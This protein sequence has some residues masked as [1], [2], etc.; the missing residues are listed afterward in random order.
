MVETI[1]PGT[2]ITVRDEGLISAGNI[3]SGIIGVVGTAAKGEVNKVYILS[4]I[5]EAQEIFGDSHEWQEGNQ[6]NLTLIRAL[7]LIYNNGGQQVYAVRTANEE[8]LKNASYSLKCDKNTLVVFTAKK[9]PGSLGNSIKITISDGENTTDNKS[10]KIIEF[11]LGKLQEKYSLV[12][13]GLKSFVNEVN[14]KSQI[15]TADKKVAD[16][17]ELL[18]NKST[19]PESFAEGSDGA[20]AGAVEYAKS[21]EK[22]ENEIINIIVL[23]GQTVNN[24]S[25]ILAAHLKKTAEIQRERIG[26]IGSGEEA[27]DEIAETTNTL[28]N[29]RLIFTAPGIEVANRNRGID[30][31]PGAY[32]AAAV[33]GLIA[34]LPVQAS[35]TNK[36]LTIKGITSIFNSSQLTKLVQNRVLVIEKRDGFRIVKGIT[37]NDAAWK[38]ITTRRTVDYAIYGVRSACNPYIGRLN[39][40]R[41]RGAMK[42]TLNGFLTR[43]V[44]DEALVGYTLEV[45]ATRKQEI[46]GIVAVTMTLQPTFSIDFIKVTMYL[47]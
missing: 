40:E 13:G 10:T 6:N 12:A 36:T 9:T 39:N 42:A 29:D 22:L 4:S 46:E 45:A 18:P 32:T 21:L 5:A 20:D 43:M 19:L 44:D 38:Q 15:V 16:S 26:I 41:V 14:N 25:E 17:S 23:A 28:N 35:P 7:E 11:S 31:L 47:S 2:Y 33:A 37:T 8:S 1:L 34:S 3:A 27:L 24:G 30:S